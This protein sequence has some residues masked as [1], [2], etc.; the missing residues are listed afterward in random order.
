M[1]YIPHFWFKYIV[2]RIENKKNKLPQTNP[3]RSAD[4][5]G[6]GREEKGREITVVALSPG[7]MPPSQAQLDWHFLPSPSVCGAS[8]KLIFIYSKS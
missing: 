7:G 6:E 2:N 1:I 3:D 8:L 5:L 4:L